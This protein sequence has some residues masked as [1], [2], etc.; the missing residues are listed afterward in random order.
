MGEPDP[1]SF[2]IQLFPKPLLVYWQQGLHTLSA[3]DDILRSMWQCQERILI[4]NT[5]GFYPPH[6]PKRRKIKVGRSQPPTS[7]RW[8]IIIIRSTT[9][10]LEPIQ[11]LPIHN[12]QAEISH[13]CYTL[14]NQ[15]SDLPVVTEQ[16]CLAAAPSAVP[17]LA[18]FC[19]WKHLQGARRAFVIHLPKLRALVNVPL[20]NVDRNCSHFTCSIN[21][22]I[23]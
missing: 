3:T 22:S 6:Y 2:P 19:L 9:P 7:S 4:Q 23:Y 15:S 8:K 14:V 12:P 16:L 10:A 1:T 5:H 17:A 13:L 20:K 18:S 21:R 11:E